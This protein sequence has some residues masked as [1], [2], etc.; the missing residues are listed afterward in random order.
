[1][2]YIRPRRLGPGGSNEVT[3]E[4]PV[5]HADQLRAYAL[6]G[7]HKAIRC[8]RRWGKTLMAETIACNAAIYGE[9][10]G[11]FSPQYKFLAEAYSDI[12]DYLAPLIVRS[13]RMEGVIR[14]STGGRIDFWSLDNDRA[15][16]SRRYHKVV[17][18]E[19][20]FCKSGMLD[21]WRKS[22]EPTLLDYLG[23]AIVTSNTNGIDPENFFYRICSEQE[24][25][26]FVEYHAPTVNNPY[27]PAEEIEALRE[28]THPLVFRQEY[29][30]EFVDFGGAAFF[31][32]GSLLENDQPVDYPLF[33]DTV[34]AVIDTAIK[35]GKEHD[36]TAV[37][38]CSSS[39]HHGHPLIVLDYDVLQIP[40]SL[41]EEWLPGVY[42]RLEELSRAC[43]AR[44]GSSG[45][46]IEDKASGTILIQQA[47]RR[48]WRATPIESK[49][50]D[51]GKD[52]R[53]INASGYVHRGMVKLHRVA[54][55]RVMVFKEVSR[56]HLLSQVVGYRVGVD[57]GIGSDDLL[58]CFVYG[59]SLALGN[60]DGF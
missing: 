23:S 9:Q 32:T 48:G 19:A 4:L 39:M 56:N 22:I 51:L 58:D 44:R 1:V 15:G 5:L 10:V 17:I 29:L 52:A 16:R 26:G 24:K 11:W 30:A 45:C 31:S 38:Y 40:G 2:S 27:M 54:Y 20:A 35:D 43:R 6:P 21:V 7:R 3:I 37:V 60:A 33:C 47:Q 53:A 46:F 50:T 28:R 57:A 42:R 12:I 34:F 8:G 25:W 14:L 49:L 59:I 18:D 36:G 13:S 41:L 55:D